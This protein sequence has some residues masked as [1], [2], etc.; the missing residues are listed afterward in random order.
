M[1]PRGTLAAPPA[2]LDAAI[3]KSSLVY[4][5]PLLGDGR[6]SACHAEVWFVADGADLLVVTASDRWRAVAI[7]K[8]HDRAR[9]WVGEHGV[10]KRANEGWKRSPMVDAKARLDGDAAAHARA[11]QL[12]GA[13]YSDGWGKWG[14]R[15]ESGLASGERVLIRYSPDLG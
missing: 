11:L 14:P 9:L 12:F 5:S 2:G 8:G 7:G 6:E 1:L 15:F 13:K 4:V 10:W 3:A